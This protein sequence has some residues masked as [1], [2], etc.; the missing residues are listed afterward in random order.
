[1]AAKLFLWTSYDILG[2]MNLAPRWNINLEYG[3]TDYWFQ[4]FKRIWSLKKLKT[5]FFFKKK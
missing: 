3:D 1:M 4:N 2:Y 5:E